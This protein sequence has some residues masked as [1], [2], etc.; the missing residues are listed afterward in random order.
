[1]I[2]DCTAEKNVPKPRAIIKLVEEEKNNLV[3]SGLSDSRNVTFSPQVTTKVIEFSPLVESNN[4]GM[5]KSI[6]LSNDQ[7]RDSESEEITLDSSLENAPVGPMQ[8]SGLTE[9]N[10]NANDI[11][12]IHR[13][14]ILDSQFLTHNF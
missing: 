9:I 14:K 7:D 8:S 3:D 13:G 11:S 5:E 12:T 1:M 10:F 6:C 2:N 4:A